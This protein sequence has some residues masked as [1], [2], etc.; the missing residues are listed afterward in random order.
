MLNRNNGS[1][2]DCKLSHPQRSTLLDHF[3]HLQP[4]ARYYLLAYQR[5]RVNFYTVE[6][7]FP[8]DGKIKE[9]RKLQ[10]L[11]SI[12]NHDRQLKH[13]Q[14]PSVKKNISIPA[15]EI[16]R[17]IGDKKERMSSFT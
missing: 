7:K 10:S 1:I 15:P 13:L 17:E 16:F 4:K 9:R 6:N 14:K 8:Y 3:G 11:P 12:G 2:K 5:P